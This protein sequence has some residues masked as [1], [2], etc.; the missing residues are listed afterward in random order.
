MEFGKIRKN[1]KPATKPQTTLPNYPQ[2]S[3]ME[4]QDYFALTNLVKNCSKQATFTTMSEC[5]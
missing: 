2:I 5:G 3:A 1:T 4:L